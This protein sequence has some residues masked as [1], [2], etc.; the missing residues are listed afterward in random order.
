MSKF[1]IL[2]Q[3]RWRPPISIIAASLWS[4]DFI[5]H[6]TFSIMSKFGEC[7]GQVIP[8]IEFSIFQSQVNLELC[9]GAL[10]SWNINGCFATAGNKCTSGIFVYFFESMVPST[11]TRVPTP[12]YF[13][14]PR[15]RKVADTRQRPPASPRQS[16][17][18]IS[19]SF[20][21]T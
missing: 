18:H 21:H 4:F 6:R 19:F 20:L 2:S 13:M 3:S 16:G 9:A 10:S 17:C 11:G 14:Q 15:K 5:I 8:G 1:C 12:S 7:A